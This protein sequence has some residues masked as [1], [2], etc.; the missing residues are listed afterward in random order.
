[1]DR[2]SPTE[3]RHQTHPARRPGRRPAL[4]VS[5][6]SLFERAADAL[7][8]PS[9]AFSTGGG[10]FR[11]ERPA[12]RP[13]PGSR[14][15]T[16]PAGY[17][18]G[19]GGG[20]GPRPP[21]GG[22]PA[23]RP[24][25]YWT[26]Y[27][28]I[29]LPVIGLLVMLSVF[30]FWV[31]NIIGDDDGSDQTPVALSTATTDPNAAADP[32][33]TLPAAEPTTAPTEAAEPSTEPSAETTEEPEGDPTEEATEEPDAEPT[34]EPADE[35]AGDGEYAAGDTVVT[36]DD[37][38]ALRSEASADGGEDTVI[39]RLDAG[40]TLTIVSGPEAGESYDWY[41]VETEDGQEGW[42]ASTLLEAAAG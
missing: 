33:A 5:V 13:E 9:L 2:R 16:R 31:D 8:G 22:P 6:A 27:L 41:E 39:T 20:G 1:M 10:G 28:R 14:T 17:P 24:E 26:D 4:V 25:R 38:V 37:Q 23:P 42:V 12:A 32:T 34:E 21:R 40:T 19:G 11:S 7:G 36:N 3:S 18:T 30:I 35:P 29:A 15:G